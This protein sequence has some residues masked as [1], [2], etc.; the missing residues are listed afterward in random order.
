MDHGLLLGLADDDHLQYALLAGR[1]GGQYLYGGIAAGDDLE[2]ESTTDAVKGSIIMHDSLVEILGRANLNA[3]MLG[4]PTEE[5]GNILVYRDAAGALQFSLDADSAENATALAL[6]GR[7]DVGVTAPISIRGDIGEID[8]R[9]GSAR[10]TSA[11]GADTR[12]NFGATTV[13]I[14]NYAGGVPAHLSCNRLTATGYILS[15]SYIGAEG[16]V[17]PRTTNA[18]DLGTLGLQWRDL[19]LDGWAYIDSL[20][21]D[22]ALDTSPMD[23]PG[24]GAGVWIRSI[25]VTTG[26]GVGYIYVYNTA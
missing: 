19:Y 8:F 16:M 10:I 13:S 25:P 3:L 6:Y 15:G 17:Y 2:F 22:V 7:L 5:G 24:A 1:V 4:G 26:V 9:S 11:V 12:I 21:I 20:R 14:V 23:V 18:H